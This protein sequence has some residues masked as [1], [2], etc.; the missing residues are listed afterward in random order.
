MRGWQLGMGEFHLVTVGNSGDLAFGA[1]NGYSVFVRI[2]RPQPSTMRYEFPI[3]TSWNFYLEFLV[4][5]FI[6]SNKMCLLFII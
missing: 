4:I 5:I 1:G 6:L 2:A 3:V